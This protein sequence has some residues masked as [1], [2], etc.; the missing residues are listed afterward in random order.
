MKHF[1]WIPIALLLGLILG[2][3]GPRED[4]KLA[5]QELDLLRSKETRRTENPVRT[6]TDWVRIPPSASQEP[7]A[8]PASAEAV[9]TNGPATVAQAAPAETPEGLRKQIDAAIELWKVRSDV[10][11]S[12]FLARANFD[13]EQTTRFDVLLSA[14][15]LRLRATIEQIAARLRAGE[16]PTPESGVQAVHALSGALATTYDEMD[17]TLPPTWRTTENGPLDLVDFIDPSVAEPLIG[18]E[19]LLPRGR[20]GVRFQMGRAP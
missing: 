20:R 18:V 1:V 16:P 11:R 6:V 9:A 3:W 17:R 13:Q 12:T 5:R 10:A 14:M 8:P 4:L 19:Q 2:G 7:A 15:N